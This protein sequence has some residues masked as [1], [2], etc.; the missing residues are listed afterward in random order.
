LAIDVIARQDIDAPPSAVS[1]VQFDPNRDPEWIGGVDR[2]ELVTDPPT[3]VGSKVRRV[4]GFMGRPIEWLMRVEAYEPE[5]HV[6]MHALQAP[7]PMD[8]D[9]RLE[10]I[11]DGRRT[12]ASI[13]IRGDAAGVYGAMP[14]PVMGWMVRRSVQ[15][16][17]KRLK[18]IV[19]S[20]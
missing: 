3:A 4:G 9:Y 6:G 5:R 11:D 8:V 10:P 17:L 19:E 15:G 12:S 18:R 13:R 2:V 14:G 16:D 7:F 20:G 1:A